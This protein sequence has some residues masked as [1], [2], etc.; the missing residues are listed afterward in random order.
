MSLLIYS[1]RCAHSLDIIDYVQK[2]T[3]FK[4][5]VKFHNI[6]TQGIPQK[7]ANSITR[8]PTLL[9]QNGKI[10]VGNEI[11][12]WLESLLPTNDF[13]GCG[14]GSACAVSSLEGGDD[15][16]GDIFSLDRY[17]QSLQPAMTREIEDRINMSV[18]D[19]YNNIKK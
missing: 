15:D 2:N 11:K 4:Q 3:T 13:G 19:A 1:P 12:A 17:G 5:M 14:F 9:T 16:D 8:V 18:S 10:L 6:N 7:Y